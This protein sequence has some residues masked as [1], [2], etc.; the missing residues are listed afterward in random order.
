ME[1]GEG[2]LMEVWVAAC[3]QAGEGMALSVMGWGPGVWTVLN[4]SVDRLWVR[5]GR[6]GRVCCLQRLPGLPGLKSPQ[7]GGPRL[8][9]LPLHMVLLG[10]ARRGPCQLEPLG[11]AG[12]APAE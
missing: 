11:A 1:W 7:E 10:W 9:R 5:D 2:A 4:G 8:A 3:V 12:A 6:E